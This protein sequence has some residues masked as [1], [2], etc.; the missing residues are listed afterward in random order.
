MANSCAS[1]D[2]NWPALVLLPGRGY[3]GTLVPALLL[4]LV[5]T[6][7]VSLLPRHL[8]NRVMAVSGGDR[9][10]AG[11]RQ[12]IANLFI[13]IIGYLVRFLLAGLLRLVHTNLTWNLV[14][15]IIANFL[16]NRAADVEVNSV[17]HIFLDNLRHLPWNLSTSFSCHILA[18]LPRD[19]VTLRGGD[20]TA[21]LHILSV[22]LLPGLVPTF[23][24]GNIIALPSGFLRAHFIVVDH[25][26]HIL[27]DSFAFFLRNSGALL[28][29]DILKTKIVRF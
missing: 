15:N 12:V 2:L 28:R 21:A 25:L 24:L 20:S 22:T 3:R 10:A 6:H 27:R 18:R 19:I 8:L 16:G 7:L 4:G 14:M 9:L 17:A 13:H 26:A 11:G 5:H 1:F 29:G 23:L